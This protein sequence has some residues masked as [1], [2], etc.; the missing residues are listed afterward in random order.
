MQLLLALAPGD[1]A[2]LVTE[3]PAMREALLEHWGLNKPLL[4]RWVDFL[5]NAAQGDLG[6][7][8]TYR[9]GQPVTD[10]VL[11]AA[12][13]SAGLLIGAIVS[14]TALGVGLAYSSTAARRPVQL[15]SVAPAFLL[16]AGAVAW[17]NELAWGAM[18]AGYIPRPG[19]FALP[20]QDHPLKTAL[21]VGVLAIGSSSLTEVHA[22]AA[23][24]LR[25]IRLSGYVEAARARGAALWPHV[26]TNLLPPLTSVIASR[27]AFLLG[28]LVVVEKV[29]AINGAGAMLWQAC[30]MRDLPLAMGITL[31]AAA[32]VASARLAGDL[33][34][35]ALD[36]RLA[37]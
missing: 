13:R 11:G 19:W 26:L 18:E 34:R 4:E 5:V 15:L 7:S 9:P 20:L 3:D 16:A 24:E 14:V 36:P 1:A 27:T 32:V 8:L 2:D 37:R 10:L 31:V 23:E 29:L 30:R 35:L 25:S 28:G 12:G 17:L 6:A 33:L 21:A 22:A